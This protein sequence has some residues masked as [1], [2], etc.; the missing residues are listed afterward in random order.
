MILRLLALLTV[1]LPVYAATFDDVDQLSLQTFIE[2]ELEHK[3]E[4]REIRSSW[5]PWLDRG[6]ID[7]VIFGQRQ[8]HKVTCALEIIAQER[9]SLSECISASAVVADMDTSLSAVTKKE[10]K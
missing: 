7:F 2:A 8:N 4:I 9:L 6:E 3:I 5:L 10:L 1:S